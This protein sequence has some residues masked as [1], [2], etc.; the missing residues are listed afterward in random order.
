MRATD[1]L[2]PSFLTGRA[3]LG[4]LILRLVFGI[5]LALHGLHKIQSPGGM[6][7]WMNQPGQPPAPVPGFLQAMAIVAEFGGGI[8]L[9]VGCLTPAAALLVAIN[10]ATAIGM[11]HLN[12]PFVAAPGQSS[13]ESAAGYLA[14]AL[15]LLLT[16][17][18]AWSVDRYLWRPRVISS[19]V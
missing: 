1:F 3:A 4:L 18:G 17:P 7:G 12:D 5:G 9:V 10:M 2:F 8:A 6:T 11:V 16:G 19:S 13:S 14:V 15:L